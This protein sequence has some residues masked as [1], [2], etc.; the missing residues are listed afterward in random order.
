M[1]EEAISRA[2]VEVGDYEADFRCV[3]P[4]GSVHWI[5]ASGHAVAGDDGRT[6][7]MVGLTL[8]I[9]ERKQAEVERA[10]LLVR[11]REAREEA[12]TI[13]QV[14]STLAGELDLQ[15]LMQ[16]ITD[17]GTKLTG[18]KFGAF[19]YNVINEQ[20]EAYMLYTLSGAP[21]EAFERF[22]I[23]RNTALFDYTFRGKG[24]V[25]SHD[26]LRH[27]D[28][29]KHPPHYG[30]PRG[31]LPVRSYL[32]APV[33][34]R[35]GAVLG[36][37]FFGHPEPGV[38]SE[39]AER[40]S[41]GI[42]SQA[43]IAIDNARLFRAAQYEIAQ[44]KQAEEA[45]RDSE[46]R[47]RA[48][49]E[50]SVVGFAIMKPDTSFLQL[51]DAF[52]AITGYT[53][54]ELSMMNYA[55]I[56]HPDDCAPTKK[57]V[58]Q[59]LAGERSSFVIEKRYR[60]KN[61]EEIWVQN[62]VSVTRDT[63]GRPLHLV[64]V[65][66]DITERKHAEEQLRASEERYR[67]VVDSQAEM[68]CR[69]RPDGTILF[70]NP[71]FA[72]ACGQASEALIKGNIWNFVVEEDQP[73]VQEI[74]NR[75][76]LEAPEARIEKRF[77]TTEG[78]RWTLWT[79]RALSF[80]TNGRLIEAQSSGIDITERKRMEEALK[81]A[82]QRK[83]EFL[84][85]LAHEL[86]NPL[87]PILN[88]AHTLKLVGSAD[89]N[90]QWAREVIE[91]QTQRLTRLVDDLLDVSRI[92]RGK[93]TIAHEPLELSTII[94]HAVETSRP[95]I[96]AR[97]HQL[98]VTLPPKP[99]RLQ[100][101]LTRLVQVV[102]N[103]LNNAAKYTDEGGQIWLEAAV[104]GDEAVIRVRDNGMGISADLLPS[105]F[106]LF[107]QADRSLD[108]SQGGL[109]IGLTLA[110]YL[111]ELHGGR[112]EARSEGHGRGSEFT[113]RLPLLASSS[114]ASAKE[115]AGEGVLPE[116]STLRI[117]VVE[118]NADSAESLAMLLRFK[119]HEVLIAPDGPSALA[120]GRSF[121]PQV[122]LCDI[123]LPGINGYEVAARL[124][125]QR[126]FKQTPLIALTGYGHEE[127][128]LHATE[129]GFDY[130]LVKPVDP[131]ALNIL[132]ASLNIDPTY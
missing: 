91:R 20:G 56:T 45:A 58:G 130:H 5:N 111:V 64:V 100:G 86:R 106:A 8:D 125:K 76:T 9:T 88:A 4:D 16:S 102:G 35:S 77:K 11:E 69:F 124:R 80:E 73:E 70:V 63:A 55:S 97:R 120:M 95:L 78:E 61:S 19:F 108:R 62:S 28:Y 60:R 72:N 110:R 53:S 47:L 119:G 3:W 79:Y 44:R 128:R 42:A 114:A 48:M 81:E 10:T 18:A 92:A 17:A 121:E 32:A 98:T 66:Q 21:R 101:D 112:V 2:I 38:F 7:R 49:F 68:L 29:G 39:R 30:M 93:V 104:E 126:A 83:D 26:I 59:L 96:D 87:A 14:S 82:D 54:D 52:C 12:E 123:G 132:I 129:A 115:S 99:A 50:S 27:H 90:Q 36:G 15:K 116:S 74:L 25:R 89:A 51:N 131:D 103:L 6:R 67:A 84:A 122:V 117:L 22:G 75:L 43:A 127:S 71:A 65:S 109:G 94:L 40:I 31:H 105:V 34:S 85:M 46:E 1:V 107:T 118:D 113:V 33:I 24:I 37:L 41:A 23:P 57:L 13:I